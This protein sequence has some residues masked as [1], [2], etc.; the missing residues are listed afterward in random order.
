MTTFDAKFELT[1]SIGA[2]RAVVRIVVDI[3]VRSLEENILILLMLCL[4]M[5]ALL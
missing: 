4:V 2:E 3:T 1:C 5:F